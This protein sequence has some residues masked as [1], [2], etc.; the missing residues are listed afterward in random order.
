MKMQFKPLIDKQLELLEWHKWFAWFP[1]RVNKDTIVWLQDVY[2]KANEF[3][4]FGSVLS[5][6]YK[7][8]ED[9]I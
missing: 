3:N 4:S 9:Q 7:L 1:V 6:K 5:W 2:R 8:Y